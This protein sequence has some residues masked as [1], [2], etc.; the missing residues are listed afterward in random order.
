MA[1]DE[2]GK[3]AFDLLMASVGL[4]LSAPLWA[5]FALAIKL[6]DGGP[7]F[8][9]QP[10]V[11]RGGR[12]FVTLKFRTMSPEA[13]R[14]SGPTYATPHDPRITR[15]GR[16]LRATALDELPQL[17]QIMAGEMSFV[18]PRPERPEFVRRYK[19]ELPSY[20]KRLQ[21]APGLTGLAQLYG[22]YNSSPRAKLRLDLLYVERRSLWLD[23]KLILLSFGVTFRGGWQIRGKKL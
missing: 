5:V 6:E 23:V 11:G 10:R 12:E 1:R 8:Y 3:R 7:V 17:L 16:L 19:G 21:V 18:G 20:E 22:H 13:E 9:R 4:V 2:K 15:V 14:E